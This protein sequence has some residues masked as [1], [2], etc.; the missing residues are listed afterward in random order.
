MLKEICKELTPAPSTIYGILRR[1]K[2]NRLKAPME[3]ERKKIIKEKA[4]ELGHID[5]HLLPKG[6][7]AN[8][9][10]RYY[11][12]AIVDSCTRIAWA[13]VVEDIRALTV[14]FAVLRLFNWINLRYEIQFSE[15][16]TDNGA[17]FGQGMGANNKKSHPFERML[18]ELGIKHRY[19]RPYRPQTNGK[20]E[21]FWRTVQEDLIEEAVFDSLEHFKKELEQYILYYNEVRGHQSLGG[22]T[23]GEFN[24][25]CQR[26]T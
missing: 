9:S 8:D 17:E 11:L 3:I 21:R 12:V 10:K 23:P 24:K 5:C 13:E 6:L 26:I 25:N 7:L 14:M 1:N 15:V 2:L 18:L 16:L 20:V 19:T 4:G 22:K